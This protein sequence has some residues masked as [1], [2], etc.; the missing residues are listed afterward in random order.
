[1]YQRM[2][3]LRFPKETIDRPIICELVK[4]YDI[5]VSVYDDG[6]KDTLSVK[7]LGF[8]H[9]FYTQNI[10]DEKI[11]G[12]WVGQDD[13]IDFRMVPSNKNKRFHTFL[14]YWRNAE[15]VSGV[16]YGDGA[17]AYDGVWVDYYC[18]GCVRNSSADKFAVDAA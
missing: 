9:D 12:F 18:G 17:V 10:L 2:Y 3:L 16:E 14:E 15:V 13:D 5:E 7:E 11:D 6:L 1:M 4:K 8:S